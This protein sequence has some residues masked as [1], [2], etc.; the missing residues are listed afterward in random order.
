M[1]IREEIDCIRPHFFTRL[2]FSFMGAG[3]LENDGR[4]AYN[5]HKSLGQ[6]NNASEYAQSNA[7]KPRQEVLDQACPKP[8]PTCLLAITGQR[9][10]RLCRQYLQ[11]LLVLFPQLVI[12]HRDFSNVGVTGSRITRVNRIPTGPYSG[13]FLSSKTSC[14]SYGVFFASMR[15]RCTR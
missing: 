12:R 10:L 8:V 3:V 11:S 7:F 13:T 2:M 9:F 5:S 15:V 1:A 6:R 14:Y 4:L